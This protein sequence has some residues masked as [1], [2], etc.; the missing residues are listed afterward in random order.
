MPSRPVPFAALI[1]ATG[2]FSSADK[3][4]NVH[5]AAA[6]F[7]IVR[8]VQQNQSRQAQAQNRRGQHQMPPQVR[9]VQDQDDRIRLGKSPRSPFRTS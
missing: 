2:Q 6:R 8:H 5:F 3:R 9:R 7:Q 1:R 4:R